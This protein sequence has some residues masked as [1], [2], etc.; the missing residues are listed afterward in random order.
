MMVM[1]EEV[2]KEKLLEESINQI[3]HSKDFKVIEARSQ[4][5]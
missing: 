3:L 5:Y 4:H 2:V 1:N